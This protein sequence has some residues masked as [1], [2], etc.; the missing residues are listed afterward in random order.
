MCVC[1]LVSHLGPCPFPPQ[2]Q[3]KKKNFLEP[4][5]SPPPSPSSSSSSF[6]F[7]L[8]LFLTALT[9]RAPES[10]R[11]TEMALAFDE[12][13]RPFIIIKEQEQKSRVRGLDA[14]KANIMAAKSVARIF[15]TSLG[16]M[17]KMVQSP[18]G[19]VTISKLR[20]PLIHAVHVDLQNVA[21]LSLLRMLRVRFV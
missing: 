21:L 16:P 20:F 17:H 2:K 15:R 18:D 5:S 6:S 9:H 8:L 1:Y 19:D 7:F 4:Y 14:Q 10:E 12:F 11:H 3:N 13:G